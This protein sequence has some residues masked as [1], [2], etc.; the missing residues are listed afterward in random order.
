MNHRCPDIPVSSVVEK[1]D[2]KWPPH[3]SDDSVVP[4]IQDNQ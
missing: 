4:I 3:H 1:E 2:S